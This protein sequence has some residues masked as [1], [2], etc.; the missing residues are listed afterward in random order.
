MPTDAANHKTETKT[1]AINALTPAQAT[2][3]LGATMI[4]L[5]DAGFLM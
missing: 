2:Q 5:V 3:R 4:A 1:V